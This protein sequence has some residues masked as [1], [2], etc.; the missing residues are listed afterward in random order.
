MHR[1]T[2]H[3]PRWLETK[4]MFLREPGPERQLGQIA[5]AY[6]HPGWIYTSCNVW[7]KEK[8]RTRAKA[9]A[10]SSAEG[11]SMPS[12]STSEGQ[13]F[14]SCNVDESKIRPHASA[15]AQTPARPEDQKH[16]FTKHNALH[17]AMCRTGE[18]SPT[19]GQDASPW[20]A[21]CPSMYSLEPRIL[22]IS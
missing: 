3:V 18:E 9:R 5:G 20:N 21:E 1:S 15:K 6:V 8:A 4:M 16:G 10:S 13:I 12:L 22:H 17:L 11:P 7:T 19:W 2:A 14:T